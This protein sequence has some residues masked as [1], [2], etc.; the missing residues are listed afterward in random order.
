VLRIIMARCGDVLTEDDLA[1]LAEPDA[2]M[3]PVEIGAQILDV[4]TAMEDRMGAMMSRL[5]VMA[6]RLDKADA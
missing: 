3:L 4:L 5:D 2:D 6:E 1:A